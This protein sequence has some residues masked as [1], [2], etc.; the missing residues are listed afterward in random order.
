MS[1]RRRD[2][3]AEQWL[4][5]SLRPRR[6]HA[7]LAPAGP[8]LVRG[9][10]GRSGAMAR[11]RS[12]GIWPV[13]CVQGTP[14]A[15]LHPALDQS[16]VDVVIDKAQDPRHAR[17]LGVPGSEPG[18]AAAGAG[19]DHV[20]VAGLATDYC[21][22]N[23]VLDALG[24][25]SQVTVLTDAIRRGRRR[26]GRLAARARRDARGRRHRQLELERSS[27]TRSARTVARGDLDV[28]G[29]GQWTGHFAAICCS[30]S[31]L[32][33]GQLLRAADRHLELASA[34]RAGRARSRPRPRR[35]RCPSPCAWRTS[36]S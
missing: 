5:G 20:N 13:H 25:A 21:V 17:L 32:L 22:K 8:R 6:R 14:G 3:G 27:R 10:G 29:Q 4:A 33:L 18:D 26:A 2:R 19:L 31:T 28:A 1:S 9:R 15:E 30:R 11:H 34:S 23:T 35:R 7:R 12:T 36:R 16:K 24:E